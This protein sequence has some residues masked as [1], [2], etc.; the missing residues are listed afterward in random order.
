MEEAELLSDKLAVRTWSRNLRW[1][2]TSIEK[3]YW[4]KG[5]R[6]NIVCDKAS[7]KQLKGYMENNI[8]HPNFINQ[9]RQ[10]ITCL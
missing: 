6:I 7:I 10:W 5:Y 2:S 8:H 9:V 3:F 4:K 1:Y